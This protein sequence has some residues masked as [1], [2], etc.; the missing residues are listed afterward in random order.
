MLRE[1]RIGRSG[2]TQHRITTSDRSLI[3]IK[4]S[5]L[6]LEAERGEVEHGTDGGDGLHVVE[7]LAVKHAQGP[8]VRE[9]LQDLETKSRKFHIRCMHAAF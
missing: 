8:R 7:Q 2:F 3:E 9:E 6:P 1:L 5:L 4:I